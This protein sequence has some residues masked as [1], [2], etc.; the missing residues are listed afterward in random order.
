MV[1]R[2]SREAHDV[3]RP[4]ADRVPLAVAITISGK[5][6]SGRPFAE[7]TMTIEISGRGAR[8]ATA[9]DLLLGGE[10]SV[11]NALGQTAAAKVLWRNET[12]AGR[13]F[14]EFGIVLLESA[15]AESL[16]RELPS[17]GQ[18]ENTPTPGTV[19]K[20]DPFPQGK[21]ACSA[22][23]SLPDQPSTD[24]PSPALDKENLPAEQ[25]RPGQSGL[26]SLA[27][28][29]NDN[30]LDAVVQA[31]D[32]E[33]TL[34]ST[35]ACRNRLETQAAFRAV[36][37]KV[38]LES[39]DS[40]AAEAVSRLRTAQE[41]MESSLTAKIEE[42]KR[43]LSDLASSAIAVVEE[44]SGTLGESLRERALNV[45][46]MLER[47]SGE[48]LKQTAS[49]VQAA[50]GE[51]AT[52]T[53][54]LIDKASGQI[55]RAAQAA[56]ESLAEESKRISESQVD[57]TAN[58]AATRQ[59]AEAALEAKVAEVFAALESID[60]SAADAVSRLRAAQ[61]AVGAS[62]TAKIEESERRLSDLASSAIGTI[63]EKSGTVGESL[64]ERLAMLE[65]SSG[66][67]L[68]QKA[69]VVRTAGEELV[70]LTTDLIDD[71]QRRISHAAQTA[72]KKLAQESKLVS[73][74]QTQAI[75]VFQEQVEAASRSVADATA[76]LAST[77][78]QAEA[79]LEAK[80]EEVSVAL[81]SID[82]SAAETVSRLRTAQQA[83][84]SSLTAS[85]E[86]TER[87]VNGLKSSAIA[88]AEEDSKT[89]AESLRER[90][91]SI[92]LEILERSSSEL[93]K[94]TASA[95]QMAGDELRTLTDRL[96][97]E[98]SSRITRAAQ[99]ASEKLAQEG[100]RISESSTAVGLKEQAATTPGIPP[101]AMA[102][103]AATRLTEA[104]RE[105]QAAEVSVA[106]ESI[107]SSA[108][109]ALSRLRTAQEAIG[110]SLTA[111][112]EETE[113]RLS[114]LVSSAIAGIEEKSGT[115]GESLRERALNVG[116]EMLE[117]SSGEL[118][119]QTASA[120][121]TAGDQLSTLTVGL[122]DKASGQVERAAQAAS[123]SL[124][125]ES[126]LIS[127][128][129][130][131]SSR[132]L[133]AQ[134]A[135][136]VR[137]AGEDLR[138]LQAQIVDETANHLRR[139]AEGVLA[140]LARDSKQMLEEHK[141]RASQMLGEQARALAGNADAVVSRFDST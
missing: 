52:L 132:E 84:E 48:L 139:A 136:A 70:T 89:F 30:H 97:D 53:A 24:S 60:S 56:S 124:A 11:E 116:L 91:Q 9:H 34:P 127:E 67:L 29:G 7:N 95:V 76:T 47:S 16:W 17:S 61:E 14:N 96:I 105:A 99:A 104:A 123:Q 41:A 107:E 93:L 102:S 12:G 46:E 114:D 57:A 58:L 54:G 21:E 85:I 106:L 83:M 77:R 113:R 112:I 80:V 37:V 6:R 19:E 75:E 126:K 35:E 62:L 59:Q 117:R 108:T 50:G 115:L 32:A 87:R 131:H 103:L 63:E 44:K 23:Q 138:S 49:A 73:K 78:Q 26:T 72:S 42:T 118:L 81:E 100:K 135:N 128:S 133:T 51:L 28:L 8:I 137:A 2:K 55:E 122:I 40:S 79:A 140:S 31:S 45:L 20:P 33:A 94:Q 36:D 65:R 110:S 111:K 98:A 121:Q 18:P 101:D 22:I 38:A 66:E 86:E 88:V 141:N 69:S 68:E 92:G 130:A 13:E 129:Q 3:I 71:A 64:R 82:S 25:G 15:A 120:V 43:R 4:V 109:E 125:Q 119:K 39:I 74:S 90:A 27:E 5:D 134:G 1:H 10:I